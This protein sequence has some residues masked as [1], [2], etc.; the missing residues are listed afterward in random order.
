MIPSVVHGNPI[1]VWGGACDEARS[2][3]VDLG[4]DSG[5]GRDEFLCV[6]FVCGIH[7]WRFVNLHGWTVC[8][9]VG[10]RA[11]FSEY[12]TAIETAQDQAHSVNICKQ[13]ELGELWA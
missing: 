3:G 4:P 7:P 12:P 1:G 6:R 2:V 13:P 5:D 9:L 11:V 8:P 10:N